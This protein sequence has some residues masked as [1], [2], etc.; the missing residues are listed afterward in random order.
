MLVE[1][2]VAT[3][4]IADHFTIA[5]RSPLRRVGAAVAPYLYLAPALVGFGIWVYRPLVQTIQYSFESWNLLPSSPQVEVGLSNYRAILS[6]P[7]FWS[8][9]ATTGIFIAGMLLF[10]VIVPALVGGMTQHAGRRATATYRALLFVPAL[11][12]PLVAGVVWSFLLAPNGGAVN[13]ALGL[14]GIPSTNWLF[15]PT[16]AKAAIVLITGWKVLG[17][18]VL[19]VG[20]GI[21][22]ISPDY[23]EAAASDRASRWQAFRTVTLPLLTPTLVFLVIVAALVSESQTIFPLVAGLTQGGPQ[24]ATT[25]IYYLLYSFGFTS[26][27][28]GEASAAAVIFFAVF[29]VIAV[30]SVLLL[31]RLSFYDD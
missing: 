22:A 2:P 17:V 7:M 31:D 26:F 20:A 24:Y 28:I 1:L 12:S 8:A 30:L 15:E 14:F 10:G 3:T 5:H 25:D 9:L 4:V 11:V 6:L 16:S 19:I 21:A 23:Y 18:S 13:R 27:D 29:S